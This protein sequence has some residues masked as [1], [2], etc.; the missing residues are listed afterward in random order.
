MSTTG[1]VTPNQ[2]PLFG[3]Y[4]KLD[5]SI[6]NGAGNGGTTVLTLASNSFEPEALRMTFDVQLYAFQAYW[7]AEICIYNLD[8]AT[9]QQLLAQPQTGAAALGQIK[10]GMVATLSAGYQNG[11]K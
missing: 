7:Y 3:R 1:T 8:Q 11:N 10:Q 9:T 6:P 5:V 4:Y 2:N